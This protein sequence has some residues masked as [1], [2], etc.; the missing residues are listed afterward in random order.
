M[1]GIYSA[2]KLLSGGIRHDFTAKDTRH[3]Y[4]PPEIYDE[5]NQEFDFDFDPCP[6]PRPKGYNSLSVE[7][8]RRNFVNPP[9]HREGKIGPTSFA[10]KAIEENQKG[11]LVVLTLP[12]QSYVNLLLEAGA[13]LRSLGRVRWLEVDTG[14]PTKNPSP[15]TAFI[16]KP[17]GDIVENGAARE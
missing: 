14:E 16:L 5:L 9:F 7:W 3:W 13:E 4:I 8:G 15:I 6:F 10:R 11:K 12:T 1:S 17:S 2:Q